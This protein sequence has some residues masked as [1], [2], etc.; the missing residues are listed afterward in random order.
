M[1]LWRQLTPT[2]LTAGLKALAGRGQ[3]ALPEAPAEAPPRPPVRL[4]AAPPRPL[5][6]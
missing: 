3:A 4:V 1:F 2:L 5:A 6:E